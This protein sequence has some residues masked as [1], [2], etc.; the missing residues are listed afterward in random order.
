MFCYVGGGWYKEGQT[1]ESLADEMKGYLDDGYTLVKTKVGGAPVAQDRERIDT[2]LSVLSS[3]SQLA[4]DANAGL[5][6]EQALRYADAFRDYGLAWFEEPAHP[7]DFEG[8]RCFVEAYGAPVATGE[9]LFS[10][11]DDV[12]NLLRYGGLRPGRDFL[13]TDVPQSYGVVAAARVVELMRAHRWE[14]ASLMPHG[15]NQM[16]LGAALG[17]GMGM[18]ESYPDV[19]GVFSGYADDARV[20]GGYLPAPTRPG[21]GFEG[22]AKLY[23]L[24]S[25]LCD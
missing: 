4:V 8:N 5:S 2:I 21:F 20:E 19:F 25:E 15:G 22:Q 1:L 6:V 24:F 3:P 17:L 13:Q 12:R 18:C 16:S 7:L 10:L 14:P 11:P 9:N 23:S